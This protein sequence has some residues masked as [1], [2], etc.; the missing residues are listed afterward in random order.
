[1]VSKPSAESTIDL[2]ELGTALARV[3]L[4]QYEECLRE[5]GFEEWETVMAITETDMMEL[6]FR[7]G[8]CRRLQRAIQDGSSSGVVP[9]KDGTGNPPVISEGLSDIGDISEVMPR[10]SQQATRTTR[11]YR[12]HPRPDPHAPLRPR[13]AY[14]LFGEHARQDL[15][16]SRLSFTDIAK[17]TGR[18][19]RELPNEER[20]RTW[21]IPAADRLQEYKEELGRYRQTEDYQSYR[22]YVE[23]FEQ[24]QHN[25]ESTTL[26]DNKASSTSKP[27]SFG[28]LPARQSQ[29]DFEA[30][31]Q[32]SVDTEDLKLD[33][34]LQATASPVKR[35]MDE[36]RHILK[37]LGIDSHSIRVAALPPKDMTARAVQAFV[38]GTGSLLYLWNQTEISNLVRS[39][40]HLQS[41]SKLAVRTEIFAISAVGSY[42]GGDAHTMLLQEQ[43]LHLFLHTLLL[44]VEMSNFHRMRLF[45]CLAICRFASSAESARRLMRK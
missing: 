43:F 10:S 17:E 37:A 22:T 12:R 28:R 24:R 14:V 9:M 6:G 4:G 26:L 27:A 11:P 40:H 16:S 30:I 19:W 32:E 21:E 42:C 36:V 8:D 33:L 18:R 20:A 41:D 25:S 45:A 35:G 13:T 15:E 7:L 29:D 39:V 23:V 31:L 34:Q 5:N 44:H 38:H 3:G 2:S 1:M